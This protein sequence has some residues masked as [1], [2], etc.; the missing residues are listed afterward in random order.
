MQ[1]G[2]SHVYTLTFDRRHA[3]P[4]TAGITLPV[5]IKLG[6]RQVRLLAKVDT[7]ASLCILQREYGEALGL[8]IER[9]T[10]QQVAT[11]TGS[12][13]TYG[14][15]VTLVTA[16]Y[17]F[18]TTVYFAAERDYHRNVLGRQ[19]WLEQVRLGI[20]DYDKQL[21]LSRYED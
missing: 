11:V 20:I 16:D 12:F 14:H 21:Y 8:D 4:D 17:E 19:G 6:E 3:Y 7:G 2:D 1:A 15:T 10:R 5:L 18:A 13:T 9:G